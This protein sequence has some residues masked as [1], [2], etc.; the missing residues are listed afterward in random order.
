M[1]VGDRLSRSDR[2]LGNFRVPARSSWLSS[3]RFVVVGMK[4]SVMEP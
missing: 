2:D 4:L 1:K 3:A